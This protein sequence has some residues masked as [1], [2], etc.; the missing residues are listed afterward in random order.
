MFDSPLWCR[1]KGILSLNLYFP[2]LVSVHRWFASTSWALTA[3]TLE[4]IR[5][6]G[7]RP[8]IWTGISKVLAHTHSTAVKDIPPSHNAISDVRKHG[9]FHHSRRWWIQSTTNN[10]QV[11]FIQSMIHSFNLMFREELSLDE[12]MRLVNYFD[13]IMLHALVML[14]L[15]EGNREV[16]FL[17]VFMKLA[18]SREEE[19]LWE[20]FTPLSRR[21][22]SSKES[23]RKLMRQTTQLHSYPVIK[24]HLID[25]HKMALLQR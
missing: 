10:A 8:R 16:D 23:Q 21:L 18:V 17:L 19:S 4:S 11:F 14:G 20:V 2:P 9:N 3:I 7:R 6:F 22:G 12:S 15:K 25:I 5:S 24:G 1:W 13:F